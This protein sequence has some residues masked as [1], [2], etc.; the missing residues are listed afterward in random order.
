[1]PLEELSASAIRESVPDLWE[2][3]FATPTLLPVCCSCGLVRDDSGSA[4][5][6]GRWVTQL[7]YRSQHGVNPADCPLTHTYCPAC[8]EQ[9][10]ERVRTFLL[11][12]GALP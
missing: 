4:S 2:P 9:A 12:I 5:D 7:I 10:Q 8:F 1:M 11:M 3:A 6:G